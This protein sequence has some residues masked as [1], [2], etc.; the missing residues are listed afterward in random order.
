MQDAFDQKNQ[1]HRKSKIENVSTSGR[2]IFNC[3][4]SQ[5]ACEVDDLNSPVYLIVYLIFHYDFQ[6]VVSILN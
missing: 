5:L 6:H 2:V 4:V 3:T 1:P